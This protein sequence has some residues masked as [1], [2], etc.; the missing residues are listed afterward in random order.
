MILKGP[1]YDPNWKRRFWRDFL[2]PFLL[3]A[4]GWLFGAIAAMAL[5]FVL[6]FLRSL[7]G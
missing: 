3:D 7:S 6:L 1:Q 2:E 4:S 5:L